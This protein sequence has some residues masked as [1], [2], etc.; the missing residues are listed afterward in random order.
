LQAQTQ[1]TVQLLLAKLGALPQE[2]RTQIATVSLWV[3]S[4]IHTQKQPV[5]EILG[6]ACQQCLQRVGSSR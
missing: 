4:D 5:R 2:L 3:Q 1:A 6:L